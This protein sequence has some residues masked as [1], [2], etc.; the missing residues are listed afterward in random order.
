MRP[1][2]SQKQLEIRRRKAMEL[3]DTGISLNEVARRFKCHA[4]SVM[5][6][7]NER[8]KY[9]DSGL[10][11]KPIPGRPSKLTASQKKM[12]IK[13]LLEGALSH[14]YRTDLWTTARIAEL[15]KNKFGVIYHQDHIGKLMASL[16]WSYQKPARRAI[17]RDEKAIE[18]WKRKQWPRIK[19]KLRGW[20]PI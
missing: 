18:E 5:R 17:E 4:S 3:L 15:I 10:A 11:P 12:L 8:E 19:K 9:G 13:L 6:W 7:R 16:S 20:A 2:G 1:F 14:G